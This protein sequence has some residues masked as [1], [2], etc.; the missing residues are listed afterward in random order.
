[1]NHLPKTKILKLSVKA[2]RLPLAIGLAALVIAMTD[3]S[4]PAFGDVYS[5]SLK[6]VAR[7][8]AAV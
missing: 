3:F 1:M 4:S 8:A 6:Q 2:A 5:R 7:T